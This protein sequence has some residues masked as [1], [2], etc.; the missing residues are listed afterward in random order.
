MGQVSLSLIFLP[1]ISATSQPEINGISSYNN[2]NQFKYIITPGCPSFKK[3][4]VSTTISGLLKCFA[5][6]GQTLN[7]HAVNYVK[8]KS[9]AGLLHTL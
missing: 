8:T 4:F 5:L 7:C 3:I 1:F 2:I 9:A 6:C